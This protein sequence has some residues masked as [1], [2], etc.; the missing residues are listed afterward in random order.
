IIFV[1]TKRQAQYI[2]EAEAK[3][4]GMPFVSLRWLGGMLTNYK[5]V[6]QSINRL[7][8]LEKMREDGTLESLNKKEMLQNIR[9]IEKLE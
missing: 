5:T 9:T 1:G 3:R 6:R 4:C 7:A 2:V 8:Q